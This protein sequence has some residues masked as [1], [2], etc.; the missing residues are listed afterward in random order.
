[1]TG[2]D[3]LY[4]CFS[5]I[6]SSSILR[7]ILYTTYYSMV[8]PHR[9]PD[10]RYRDSIDPDMELIQE[11]TET[12]NSHATVPLKVINYMRHIIGANS[13]PIE[14]KTNMLNFLFDNK[15]EI[16]SKIT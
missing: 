15:Y 6:S 11:I 13:Y 8:H 12:K 1:M 3:Q 9:Q 16:I 10:K 7:P 2:L 14:N 5:A 4:V